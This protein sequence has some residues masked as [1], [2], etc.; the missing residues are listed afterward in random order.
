MSLTTQRIGAPEKGGNFY[1]SKYAIRVEGATGKAVAWNP[2]HPHGTT[3][4][5]VNYGDRD[6]DDFMQRGVCTAVPN[7]VANARRLQEVGLE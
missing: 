3:L 2:K 1:N 7:R 6:P 4:Q 5:D